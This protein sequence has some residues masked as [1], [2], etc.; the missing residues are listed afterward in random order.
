[1]I[2]M[3][4]FLPLMV[5]PKGGLDK[6]LHVCPQSIAKSKPMYTFMTSSVFMQ[7]V[8]FVPLLPKTL[9][10]LFLNYVSPPAPRHRQRCQS[11]T[12]GVVKAMTSI[13]NNQWKT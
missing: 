8:W 7:Q 9:L 5:F 3:N 1:M 2:F 4:Q 10:F 11:V 12:I 6:W 13:F